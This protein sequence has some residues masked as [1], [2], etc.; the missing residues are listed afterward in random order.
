[1][2]LFPVL[3]STFTDRTRTQ[4]SWLVQQ[5]FCCLLSAGTL[6]GLPS[7]ASTGFSIRFGLKASRRPLQGCTGQHVG[8]GTQEPDFWGQILVCRLLGVTSL[9]PLVLVCKIGLETVLS[10]GCY[11]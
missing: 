9:C 4:V 11:K 5:V 6:G 8:A 2:C 3:R 10:S 7:A 1:M